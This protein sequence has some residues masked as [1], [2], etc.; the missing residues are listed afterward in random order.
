METKQT[1]KSLLT[2]PTLNVAPTVSDST[3]NVE[4]ITVSEPTRNLIKSRALLFDLLGYVV[5]S[6]EQL[7][8]YI[9]KIDCSDLE[10]FK[11]AFFN[12]DEELVKLLSRLID[13]TLQDSN[14]KEL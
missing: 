4:E 8:P 13:T 5:S 11:E 7:Y 2:K 9:D 3:R 10:A 14:Y 1:V 6:M 12:L